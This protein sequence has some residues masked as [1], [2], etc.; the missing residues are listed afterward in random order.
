MKKYISAILVPCLLMQLLS[1]CTSFSRIST[2]DFTH[3]YIH[4]KD[5]SSLEILTIDST[6]YKI[7]HKSYSL[8]TD[9]L[10]AEGQVIDKNNR[11]EQFKG[12]IPLKSIKSIY[13]NSPNYFF[14]PVIIVIFAVAIIGIIY[15]GWFLSGKPNL[16]NL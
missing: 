4:N 16:T 9:T 14:I 15:L 13:K 5:R 2:D 8:L 6:L 1:G 3:E 10:F 11:S 7:E 12:K